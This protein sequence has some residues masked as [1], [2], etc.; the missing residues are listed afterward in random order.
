[1]PDTWPYLLI[2]AILVLE[3]WWTTRLA[4]KER[5][6]L[7]DRLMSKSLPEY[8]ALEAKPKV[9]K[10]DAP[11]ARAMP[12]GEPQVSYAEAQEGERGLMGE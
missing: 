8:K 11:I 1:M 3:R 7:L 4:V 12:P 2:I 5:D 9:K 10:Q 6:K